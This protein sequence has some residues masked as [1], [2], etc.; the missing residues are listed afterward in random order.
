MGG[1]RGVRQAEEALRWSWWWLPS[2]FGGAV[3]WGL[4]GVAGVGLLVRNIR[5][6][7]RR[8]L[9]WGGGASCG[10]FTRRWGRR[11]KGEGIKISGFAGGEWRGK[12]DEAGDAPGFRMVFCREVEEGLTLVEE[13]G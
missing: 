9:E 7:S 5:A 11:I 4:V 6:L 13:V 8:G 2:T 3:V 1:K 10:K 12:A